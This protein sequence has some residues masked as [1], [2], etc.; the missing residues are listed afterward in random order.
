LTRLHLIFPCKLWLNNLLINCDGR[1][2]FFDKAN[3]R[4]TYPDAEIEAL[5]APYVPD[6]IA[7]FE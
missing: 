2:H 7:G 1:S 6:P 5:E 3:G 4:G